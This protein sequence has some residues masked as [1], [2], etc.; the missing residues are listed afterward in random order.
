MRVHQLQQELIAYAKEIGIDKIGFT[1]V[2]P[3]ITLKDRLYTQQKLGYASG[4]EESNIELRTEP[5]RLL[6]TAQS[7]IAIAVAYPSKMPT[8]IAGKKGERRGIFCR[9][10]W[11]LDYHTVLRERLAKLEDW[12]RERVP[13]AELKSMVDTGELVDRA[14]AERAGIGWSGKNCSII[15]PEFGS[16]VYL[17]EMLTNIP[18]VPDEP[19][20]DACLDCRLCLDVCPTTALVAPGQLDAQRCI[21]YLTQTKQQMPLEFRKHIGNRIYGCDTCQTVCP[22]NKGK[23]NLWHE[24]FQPKPEQVKPLLTPLLQ[25]TNRQFKERFGEMS[26]AWRGK[27]PIQRNAI[28]ALAHFKEQ[29]ALPE[30]EKVLLTDPRPDIRATAAYAIGEIAEDLTLLI[31]AKQQET[32]EAVVQEINR[33]LGE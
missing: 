12:L 9:A 24:E 15:T 17:G 6:P 31:K 26:G 7:I 4:F 29:S 28:L 33:I 21:A 23:T 27:K 22:K 1:T 8:H 10:S 20:E 19:M 30:L 13:N 25:M 2:E 11:G 32:D 18:F 5:I 3:F 16:Y 14:V